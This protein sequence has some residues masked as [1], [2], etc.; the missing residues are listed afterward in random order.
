MADTIFQLQDVLKLFRKKKVLTLQELRRE[1]GCSTMTV[2][3]LLRPHG[4]FTSYNHNARDYTLAGIPKFDQHG[5]WSF[6]QARFSKW[7][8][9]TKTIIGL[10]QESSDGLTA[11]QLQQRLQVK[12]VKPALTRLMQNELLTREK[13]GG[14]FVYF[15][16]H[17]ASRRRQQKQRK[18][19]QQQARAARTLPPLEQIIAL[20]VEI[21]RRPSGTPRQWARRLARE[22]VALSTAGI[23]HVLEHYQIDPKKGLLKS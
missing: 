21:I 9:L 20:L 7:G 17:L 5:L 4:Y 15:A 16:R 14:R 18:E 23:Q 3:R 11:E 10:V 8:S 2:W 6:R 12:N 1:T 19:K 13:A 22:G